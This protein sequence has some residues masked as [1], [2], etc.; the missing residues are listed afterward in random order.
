MSEC[1]AH[2]S[3]ECNDRR[4]ARHA[5]FDVMETVDGKLWLASPSGLGTLADGQFHVVIPGGPLLVDFM[6]KNYEFISGGAAVTTSNVSPFIESIAEH[7]IS[8]ETV[9]AT[10]SFTHK[11]MIGRK[12]TVDFF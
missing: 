6:M 4:F 1:V 7:T 12:C 11:A 5:V 9:F 8:W 10:V 2:R 3:G